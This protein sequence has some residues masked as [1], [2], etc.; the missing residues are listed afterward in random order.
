IEDTI[1]TLSAGGD[2]NFN[3]GSILL[4]DNVFTGGTVYNNASKI[5][6]NAPIAINGNYRQKS[7]ATLIIGVAD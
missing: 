5:Q 3:A 2:I 4:N 1:G 7:D 6:V